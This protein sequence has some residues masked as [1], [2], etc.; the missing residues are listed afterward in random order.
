MP[1]TRLRPTTLVGAIAIVLLS[2]CRSGGESVEPSGSLDHTA[3]ASAAWV[4]RGNEPG[5]RVDLR[6]DRLELS[7][8]DGESF[9]ATAIAGSAGH[10]QVAETNT[11]LVLERQARLC[12]DSA[13]GMPHPETVSVTLDDETL[14]G[15][16][17]EPRSLLTGRDWVVTSLGG[18]AVLADASTGPSLRFDADGRVSGGSGCNRFNAA[19]TL[20]GEGLRFGPIAST[21]MACVEPGRMQS[22][23]SFLDALAQVD[24]FDIDSDG[25]LQLYA[26]DRV[27]IAAKSA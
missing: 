11:H 8:M 16:G 19:Y 18:T 12:R 24:R 10:Y 7:R 13:T 25:R 26:A 14:L 21:K 17:G 15:C 6:G 3:D 1:S 2:A 20:D 9:T 27:V 4:A 5:W 22:E 23:Q